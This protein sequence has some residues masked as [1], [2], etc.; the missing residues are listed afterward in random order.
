MAGLLHKVLVDEYRA[1]LYGMYSDDIPL[2]STFGVNVGKALDL[3]VE[4]KIK[5]IQPGSVFYKIEMPDGTL[6]GYFTMLENQGTLT[7]SDPYLRK[8]FQTGEF[9]KLV[10]DL[11]QSSI[12]NNYNR[13]IG[14]ANFI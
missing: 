1:L 2:L 6:M 9:D 11:I 13:S 4:S 5:N 14:A 10:A 7:A 3:C 8:Q 12:Q